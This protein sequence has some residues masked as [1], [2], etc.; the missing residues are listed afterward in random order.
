MT[1]WYARHSKITHETILLNWTAV[2]IHICYNVLFMIVLNTAMV[3]PIS[4]KGT[5]NWLLNG[6]GTQETRKN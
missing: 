5:S 3:I 1:Y 2:V 4:L 6:G